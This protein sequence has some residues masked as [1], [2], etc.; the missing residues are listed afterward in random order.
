M[1][2]QLLFLENG[3]TF[4]D[5]TYTHP[6]CFYSQ[7]CYTI[8]LAKEITEAKKVTLYY[9]SNVAHLKLKPVTGCFTR[10]IF[11]NARTNGDPIE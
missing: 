1:I 11:K 7:I 2:F 6:L 5:A 3:D 10:F 8:N 4:V 9:K